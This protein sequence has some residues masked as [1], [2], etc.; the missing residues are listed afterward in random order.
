MEDGP[1]KRTRSTANSAREKGQPL[2]NYVQNYPI[3]NSGSESELFKTPLDTLNRKQKNKKRDKALSTSSAEDIRD[4]FHR[5]LNNTRCSDKTMD[6][7]TYVKGPIEANSSHAHRYVDLHDYDQSS[8]TDTEQSYQPRRHRMSTTVS[9]INR[10]N[11]TLAPHQGA[12]NDNNN[13]PSL[14]IYEKMQKDQE[15][16]ELL[17]QKN[18]AYKKM[19]KQRDDILAQ[20]AEQERQTDPT[21]IESEVENQDNNQVQNQIDE[22]SDS[23]VMD[24]KLVMQMFRELKEEMNKLSIHEGE[25][26]VKEVEA[27]QDANNNALYPMQ[28]QLSEYKLKTEILT[29]II[30]NMNDTITDMDKRIDKIELNNMKKSMVVSGFNTQRSKKKCI[31]ELLHFFAEEM[32]I[33][34]SIE[35]VFFLTQEKTNPM[36]VTFTKFSDKLLVYKNTEKIKDLVNEEDKPFF[37]TDYLPAEMSERKRRENEIFRVNL[38]A[39]QDQLDMTR[40]KRRTPN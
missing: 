28:V 33:T 5:E 19:R 3:A 26:R 30:M 38:K 29:G 13:M 21:E 12:T 6:S 24:V 7:Q 27:Q 16:C 25:S 10:A 35:D 22:T 34:P 15:E 11:Q 20:Q 18:I 4:F 40:K 9:A 32:G 23:P 31:E 39:T 14:N 2:L 17:R 8:G 37:Y 1:A 36:V